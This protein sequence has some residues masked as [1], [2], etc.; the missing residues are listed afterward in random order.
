MAI[1]LAV[2]ENNNVIIYNE[3][4]VEQTNIRVSNP[5]ALVGWNSNTV[6]I[7]NGNLIRTYDEWGNEVGNAIYAKTDNSQRNYNTDSG[8]SGWDTSFPVRLIAMIILGIFVYNL[9]F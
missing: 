5:N 8:H 6:S 9:M 3:R 4:G 1:N 7:Q 2:Q